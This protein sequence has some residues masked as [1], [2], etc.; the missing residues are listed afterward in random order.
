MSQ[1]GP[2][3]IILRQ[4]AY[5][6]KG[7]TIHSAGQL[8]AY[9]N[10]VEDQSMK[11]GGLQCIR[12]RDGYILPLDIINGL[13]YLKMQPNT[14]QEFE[15]YPSIILTGAEEWNPRVLDHSLTD[16]EDWYETLKDFDHGC[17]KSPFDE[18]GNYRHRTQPENIQILPEVGTEEEQEQ[19]PPT[20]PKHEDMEIEIH[21]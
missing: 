11:A 12:T 3:I 15:D 9:K 5:L 21:L 10:L 4:Y 16:Q 1:H 6:G 19:P 7:R 8:E 2:V 13:P 17:L 20:N 14:D 18:Y